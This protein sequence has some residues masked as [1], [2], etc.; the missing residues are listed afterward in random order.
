[1]EPVI[2][3]GTTGEIDPKNIGR[4]KIK[5]QRIEDDRNRQVCRAQDLAQTL[6]DFGHTCFKPSNPLS[7]VVSDVLHGPQR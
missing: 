6:L 2:A 7:I 3:E 4:K 1:M 5:I